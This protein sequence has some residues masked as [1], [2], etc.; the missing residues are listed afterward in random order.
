[1]NI[2]KQK[3]LTIT[4]NELEFCVIK[5]KTNSGEIQRLKHN[6]ENTHVTYSNDHIE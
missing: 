2:I 4:S 5:D 6:K 1:M 3:L